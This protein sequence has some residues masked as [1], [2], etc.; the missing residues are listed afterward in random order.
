MKMKNKILQKVA[1]IVMAI[2]MSSLTAC[3]AVSPHA[4]GTATSSKMAV[5]KG[6]PGWNPLSLIAVQ[7]YSID[8]KKIN[9]KNTRIELLPGQHQLKVRCSREDPEPIQRFYLFDMVLKAGHE[10][11]PKLDMTQECYLNYIDT[12][13]GKLFMGIE[14]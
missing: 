12:M 11:K 10:Y 3:G 9:G 1:I 4:N 14:E 7:I 8:G 13:T 2:G 5:I 6:V